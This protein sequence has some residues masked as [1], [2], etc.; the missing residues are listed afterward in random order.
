M[1]LTTKQ[2]REQ[3]LSQIYAH[4]Q[5]EVRDLATVMAVSEAT[6]R[7]DLRALTDEGQ[8]ELFYGGAT[9]PRTS[10]FSFRSKSLR[11]VDAK[12]E[13]GR[14]AAG[15]VADH[16]HLYLDSG[17]TCF[18][19][20][21]QLRRKRGL[22]VIVNSARLAAE[23]ANA[24]EISVIM[25]GGHYRPDRMDTIGPLAAA[26]ID[27]LRGYR[28]FIGADGLSMEFGVTAS[29][30]DSAHLYRQTI[31][32]ARETILVV[33]HTKFLTPSLFKIAGF[34][35]FSRVVTDKAPS[36]EWIEFFNEKGIDVL[37]SEQVAETTEE[38]E[39][40]PVVRQGEA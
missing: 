22:S 40:E 31:H 8:I 12:R 23:L 38:P 32:N 10:D 33:D 6:V 9:L 18:E 14:L 21:L 24:T 26:T 30:I 25:I 28:A 1:S 37:Y 16:D 13:I 34:D 7:R 39:G 4:G 29:D 11:N 35:A 15:L 5:A 27:Q 36:P 3:I 20:C 19:L 2:R 17:T